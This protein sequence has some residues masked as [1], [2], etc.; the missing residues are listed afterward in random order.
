[1]AS[2]ISTYCGSFSQRGFKKH[3]AECSVCY[4]DA[5]GRTDLDFNPEDVTVGWV[6]TDP[7]F[8]PSGVVK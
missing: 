8:G 5:L 3:I 7:S 6:D 1:M 4:S 2:D